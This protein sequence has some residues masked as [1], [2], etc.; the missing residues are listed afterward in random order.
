MGRTAL[1]ALRAVSAV[2]GETVT[3]LRETRKFDSFVTLRTAY[4]CVARNHCRRSW[5]EIANALDM[6]HTTLM[7]AYRK[8]GHRHDVQE[9]AHKAMEKL[10][11][12]TWRDRFAEERRRGFPLWTKAPPPSPRDIIRSLV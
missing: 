8:H 6:D 9:I 4:A 5:L 11:E 1:D 7:H 10:K 3:A 2:T 12:P